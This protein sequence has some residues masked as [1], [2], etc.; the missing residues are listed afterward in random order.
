VAELKK[1]GVDP[2]NINRIKKTQKYI[3]SAFNMD[4]SKI[5]KSGPLPILINK[6]KNIL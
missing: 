5:V 1:M 2:I 3:E 4:I 6:F